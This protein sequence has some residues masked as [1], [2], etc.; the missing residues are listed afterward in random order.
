MLITLKKD[1]F[2]CF[3]ERR[4]RR[5]PWNKFERGRRNTNLNYSASIRDARSFA[6]NTHL[7]LLDHRHRHETYTLLFHILMAMV[8]I[9]CRSRHGSL[10][11]PLISTNLF[12]KISNDCFGGWMNVCCCLNLLEYK[13]I[14]HVVCSKK[15]TLKWK[16]EKVDW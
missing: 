9:C 4:T 10:R 7:P 16:N 8:L 12:A 5:W 1:M 11:W 2:G 3:R 14:H 13:T 15:L 6:L